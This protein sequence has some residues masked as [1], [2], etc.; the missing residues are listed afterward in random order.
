MA[1]LGSMPGAHRGR[2]LAWSIGVLCTLAPLAAGAKTLKVATAVPAGTEFIEALRGASDTMAERTEGRVELKLFPGGTMG[3]DSAVLR[4][5]KIGQL[6]GAVV[7]ASGLAK[8]HP[9]AQLYSM[10]FLFRSRDE[11]AYVRER[12]DP[13][14]RERLRSAGYVVGGISEGGFTYLFAQEPIRELADLEGRRMWVPEGDEITARMFDKAGGEPVSLPVSDVFTSLQSGMIDTVAINPAGAI[15]LQWHTGVRYQTDAPLLFLI[16]MLVF[17]RDVFEQIDAADREIVHEVLGETFERLDAIN[18][19]NNREA[20]EALRGQ[21][22]ELVEPKRSAAERRWTDVADETLREFEREGAYD[23][24][25]LE[26]IE[27]LVAEYR[28][29]H[30]D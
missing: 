8:I 2:V 14:M 17:D 6:D 27:G 7:T 13:V 24:S 29:Q 25:L 18:R 21:G 15:A 3:K 1:M 22:V 20:G 28:A 30:G 16:A 26:R 23:A 19:D 10:P 12:I 9:D 5:M 4:K 11:L